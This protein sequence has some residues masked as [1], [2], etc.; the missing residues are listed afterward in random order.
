MKKG[1]AVTLGKVMNKKEHELLDARCTIV[2]AVAE[3]LEKAKAGRV[4]PED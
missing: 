2:R 1:E 4:E 3:G